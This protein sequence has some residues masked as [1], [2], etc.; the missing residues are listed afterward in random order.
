MPRSATGG[1]VRCPGSSSHDFAVF[2]DLVDGRSV[3]RVVGE[4]DVVTVPALHDA[5]RSVVGPVTIDARDLTFVDAHALGALV[6][7]N[8]R[9]GVSLLHASAHCRRVFDVCG[10]SFLLSD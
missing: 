9:I 3:V 5:L 6:A 7:V 10:L 2:D 8:N 4:L 1:G